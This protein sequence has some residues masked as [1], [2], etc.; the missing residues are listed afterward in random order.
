MSRHDPAISMQQ[1]RDHAREG[2]A[3]TADRGRGD[4]AGDRQLRFALERLLEIIGETARRV[5]AD[6]QTLHPRVAWSQAIGYRN[7]LAHGY[8][9]LNLDIL[10]ET[11]TKDLPA[12]VEALDDALG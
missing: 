6:S 2:V 12:L 8:D 3:M 4:L 11:V 7:R 10:W 5:P 1:M 9:A